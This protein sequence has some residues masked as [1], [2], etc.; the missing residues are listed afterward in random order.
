MEK[1]E[2]GLGTILA[3]YVAAAFMFSYGF[4][5]LGIALVLLGV[6][7][8]LCCFRRRSFNDL[9][10]VFHP[11]GGSVPGSYFRGRNLAVVWLGSIKAESKDEDDLIRRIV[12][13]VEHETVHHAFDELKV[14]GDIEEWLKREHSSCRRSYT[15]I[16][17][18]EE[19]MVVTLTEAAKELILGVEGLPEYRQMVE[20][21]NELVLKIERVK[22]AERRLEKLEAELEKAARIFKNSAGSSA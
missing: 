15:L 11:S 16:N 22:E 13:T 2:L 7:V 19:A 20:R 18:V 10:F 1:V 5:E 21:I 9:E 14:C 8:P 6:L 17:D 4:A 12:R 3:L